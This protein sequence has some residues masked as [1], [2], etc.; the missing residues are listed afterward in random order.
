MA[1]PRRV[2]QRMVFHKISCDRTEKLIPGIR[3]IVSE[4]SCRVNSVSCSEFGQNLDVYVKCPSSS[5][6][7]GVRRAIKREI[8]LMKHHGVAGKRKR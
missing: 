3:H 7:D 6:F 8:E 2:V 1:R 4:E 5:M